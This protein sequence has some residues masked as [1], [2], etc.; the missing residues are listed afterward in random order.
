MANRT[1]HAQVADIYDA[2]T[3]IANFEPFITTANI[4][5][6]TRLGSSGLT[7]DHLAQ[8]ETYLAAH[9]AAIKEKEVKTEQLGDGNATYAGKTNMGLD[10]TSYGQQAK[11]IDT[12]GLLSKL[13]T[14]GT[15]LEFIGDTDSV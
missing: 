11:V 12:T 15:L 2:D 7:A 6:T 9:F 8:I 10:Y 3:E 1:T 13:G 14:T 5:V 4:L